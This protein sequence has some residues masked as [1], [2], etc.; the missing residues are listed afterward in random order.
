M[1]WVEW[2]QVNIGGGAIMEDVCPSRGLGFG[3]LE[4]WG[5]A[6]LEGRMR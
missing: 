5:G 1:A 4:M 2:S 3:D 6:G